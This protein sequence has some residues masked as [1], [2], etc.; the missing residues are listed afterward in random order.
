MLAERTRAGMDRARRQ[1]KRVGRPPVT[2]RP[3][4]AERWAEVRPAVAAGTLTHAAAARRLGVGQAE[5]LRLLRQAAPP[6]PDGMP[7]E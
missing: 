6:H 5:L 4:F 1:G 7:R 2:A 3:K